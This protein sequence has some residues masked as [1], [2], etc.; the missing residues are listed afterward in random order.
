MTKQYKL[1]VQ[2][3][4]LRDNYVDVTVDIVLCQLSGMS[5]FSILVTLERNAKDVMLDYEI[6]AKEKAAA[7]I[8]DVS[9]ELMQTA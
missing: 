9:I 2:C 8:L 4:S 1:V 5:L 7:T 3:I 6:L